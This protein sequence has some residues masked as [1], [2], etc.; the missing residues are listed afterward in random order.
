ML[1]KYDIIYTVLKFET[2]GATPKEGRIM[3]KIIIKADDNGIPI[4]I[5][6]S[7]YQADIIYEFMEGIRIGLLKSEELAEELMDGIQCALAQSG[8]KVEWNILE[9]HKPKVT[10]SYIVCERYA[11]KKGSD[12]VVDYDELYNLLVKKIENLTGKKV[13]MEN[14]VVYDS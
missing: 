13:D 11:D 4:D 3:K 8:I 9:A 2:R 10:S 14:T 6:M 5:I 1:C 12:I 7:A